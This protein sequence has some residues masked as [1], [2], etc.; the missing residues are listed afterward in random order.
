M[1]LQKLLFPKDDGLDREMYVRCNAHRV[2]LEEGK[3]ASADC[4]E[5]ICFDTYFG[6]FS[7]QK[8][9]KY[10]KLDNLALSLA[11]KG[12]CEVAL[13]SLSLRGGAVETEVRQNRPQFF[14]MG[15]FAALIAGGGAETNETANLAGK[16]KIEAHWPAW[17]D[18][19]GQ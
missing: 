13:L 3:I 16:A 1:I 19:S 4:G 18:P 7:Y 5:P 12:K 15:E 14:G 11:I 6:S 8:W 9:R 10:T 2:T 17:M